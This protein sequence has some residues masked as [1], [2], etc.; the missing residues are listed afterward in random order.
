MA[1]RGASTDETAGIQVE[2]LHKAFERMPQYLRWEFA[3]R[4][5]KQ[6]PPYDAEGLVIVDD[7]ITSLLR[8]DECS[9]ELL[10]EVE[11]KIWECAQFRCRMQYKYS[12]A[13]QLAL[14]YI[15]LMKS[16]DQRDRL[17]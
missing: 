13:S 1:S 8:P 14:D 10:A 16:D 6:W 7:F 5:L 17:I 15:M 4:C 12:D 11:K 9:G 3:A 2:K